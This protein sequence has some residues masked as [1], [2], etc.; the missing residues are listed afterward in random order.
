MFKGDV[1]YK[2][3]VTGMPDVSSYDLTGDEDFL[4]LAC[5]GLWDVV[6]EQLAVEKVYDY[7]KESKGKCYLF[8]FVEL[9]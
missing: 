2:P 9:V 5:D 6:S 3:Y 4:L 8:I 7:L 1:D